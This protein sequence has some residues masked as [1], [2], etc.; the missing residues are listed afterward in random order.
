MTPDGTLYNNVA[1][2]RTVQGLA[3]LIEKLQGRHPDLPGMGCLSGW[4]GFGKTS[5]CIWAVNSYGCIHVEVESTWSAKYL[6]E[7]ILKE[8]GE[9][10]TGTVAHMVQRIKELL[11]M[12]DVPLLIDEADHLMKKQTIEIIRA[13]YDGSLVPVILVGEEEMPSKL[14]AWERV[15]NRIGGWAQAQ[16]ADLE[17]F[18][19]LAEIYAPDIT[20]ENEL[21]EHIL[22]GSRRSLR[23][24]SINLA[25]V[26]E[27]ALTKG[28]FSIG[29]NDWDD[30]R[31]FTGQA[32]SPRSLPK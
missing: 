15:H 18:F 13:I 26:R 10:P 11:A 24:I 12:R 14:R 7:S 28:I 16:P 2:L 3:T 4:S 6:C 20:I 27:V 22:A 29:L 17:E 31:L 19:C 23:R 32:P 21:A 1:P 8:L 25:D 9:R 30:G 5:A